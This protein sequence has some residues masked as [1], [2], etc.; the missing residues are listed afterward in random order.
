MFSFW[1]KQQYLGKYDVIIIG[2]GF[3]GLS[4]G[5][6]LLKSKPALR[7]AIIESATIGTLASSRNAGFM[8]YGSPSELGADLGNHNTATMLATIRAKHKGMKLLL[9]FAGKRNIQFKKV[10]GYEIL[11]Q[12]AS[13]TTTAREQLDALNK[14][15]QEA[16]GIPQY[17]SLTTKSHFADG[18]QD[19]IAFAYEGQLNPAATV[20]ALTQLFRNLG[21]IH[22]NAT[23]AL[24]LEKSE[25]HFEV[26]TNLGLLQGQQVI[27]ATNAFTSSLIPSSQIQPKRAQ[28]LITSPIAKM[29]YLGNFHM[30]FGYVY[31]RNVGN[32]LL[33]G[34]ARNV[35]F[36]SEN[37]TTPALNPVIQSALD[38]LLGKLLPHQN[39]TIEDRWA[40]IMGFDSQ[41]VP[42]VRLLDSN[43]L[44]VAGMNGMGTALGPALGYEAANKLLSDRFPGSKPLRIT[45]FL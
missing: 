3:T 17:Y 36:E 15:F 18:F 27:I 22:L 5:I 38:T 45:A 29:P 21:G 12:N 40:G 30:E 9:Q 16:V 19:A 6:T 8:C 14:L 28:V 4:A 13:A 10:A 34:G 39:Y 24:G 31:F 25:G 32:R 33:L 42:Q 35:D 20:Y 23:T 7:V 1:E 43:L 26:P 37:S 41:N 2:S 44:V 11:D